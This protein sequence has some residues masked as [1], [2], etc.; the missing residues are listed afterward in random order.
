MFAYGIETVCDKNDWII[1]FT[2]S[3][4]HKHDGRTF[5]DLYNKLADVGMKYYIVDVRY[6]TLVIAK[7]LSDDGVMSA[8]PY[9]RPMTKND[10]FRKSEY[11]YN[12]YNDTYIYPGNHL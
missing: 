10:F 11:V 1:S 3:P 8:F 2:V 12:E 7:L 6:K 4:S 5:K 9:K